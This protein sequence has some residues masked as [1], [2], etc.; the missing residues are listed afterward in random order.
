MNRR[1]NAEQVLIAEDDTQL[2][3]LLTD[4]LTEAG[5][6]VYGAGTLAA[7]IRALARHEIDLVLTDLRLPDGDGL[8]LL[9]RVRAQAAAPAFIVITAFG[10]VPQA[11]DAVRS[12]AEDF[13]T[14]PLNLDHVTLAVRRALDTRRLRSEVRRYRRLLGGRDF[15]GL[16]GRSPAMR[17]LF[18]QVRTIAAGSGPVLIV[19]ESGTGK[20]LVARAVHAESGRADQRFVA[21][22]CAGI[23]RELLESEFFGHTAGAFTGAGRAREGLFVEADG[24]TLLLDEIAEMPMPLQGKLLRVLQDGRVRPVG[25]ARE[26]RVEVR[27]IAA[28]NR[29]L[30]AAMRQRKLRKDLFYRLETFTLRVPPL[31]ERDQDVELLATHFLERFRAALDRDVRGFSHAALALLHGYPYPGNVR[32]LENAIERAVTF[33]REEDIAPHHLP[34]RMRANVA[35]ETPAGDGT[36]PPLLVPDG[37]LPPLKDI[38]RRYIRYVLERTGGNKRRAAELLGIGRRTLYRRL[39]IRDDS[40]GG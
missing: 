34:E 21:V 26:R 32:E 18:D 20:E 11:V 35:R 28:T 19:G 14:K 36:G 9:P 16:I 25:G 24:G 6:R 13:L 15:H 22:N 10:S 1:T 27:I 23:P 8:T 30:E 40:A 29:D 5:L 39:G 7:A 31:R 4:E 33:C 17:R 12:G 37:A 38:E 3:A 2:R